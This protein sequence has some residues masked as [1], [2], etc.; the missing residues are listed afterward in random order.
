MGDYIEILK[1]LT[2]KPRTNSICFLMDDYAAAKLPDSKTQLVMDNGRCRGVVTKR[3]YTR[4]W[5]W[6]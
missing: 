1:V 3:F 5:G 2:L 6:R 4:L